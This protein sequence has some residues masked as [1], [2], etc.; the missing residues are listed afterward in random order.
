MADTAETIE[1]AIIG[2]GPAGL[3]A[4]ETLLEAGYRPVL[5]D[6]MPTPARK[7]LMAGKSGLNLTHSENLDTFV[8]R[9]GD[10]QGK[11]EPAIR[12]FTPDTLRAWADDHMAQTFVGSSGRVFPKVF[13]ASPLLRTWLKKLFEAG[14][15][16]KTRHKWTGWDKNLCLTFDTDSGTHCVKAK[17][18]ILSLGG[19]SWPK[20]GSDGGWRSYLM[21]K[22]IFVTPFK[23]ANC[24]FLVDWS[25]HYKNR[26]AG[27]PIK[28]CLLTA[29]GHQ[30]KG[31]F[32]I[33]DYGIEGSAVYMLSA[34]LR[35]QIEAEGYATLTLDLTPDRSAAQLAAAL[36]K[37]RGK[38]T[39]STHL[40]RTTGL[41]GAKANLLRERLHSKA[42]DDPKALAR[43]I[44]ALPLTLIATRPI[45]EAI[46]VA[47]GLSFDELDDHLMIKS[48]PGVFAAGE[49]LDWEAPTG[50][51][52]LTACFA[53]GKQAAS[54]AITFLRNLASKD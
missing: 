1:V 53:Q 47:G 14:A 34:V 2:A 26:F 9:Y 11:I 8:T 3:M 13:K 33:T 32:V 4:A 10:A 12:D 24:G 40:K 7:F 54:G 50:G 46:S 42:L 35:D 48:M 5:F 19:S 38:K 29:S 16:L 22:G 41:S 17:C 20:L 23:P 31:D 21:E 49:M 28:N 15:L 6:A 36:A 52:L 43:N 51:Y 18:T 37:P 44:K 45:E 27:E 39:F 25:Q 30:L